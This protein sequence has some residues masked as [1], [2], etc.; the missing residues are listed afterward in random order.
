MVEVAGNGLAEPTQIVGIGL[1]VGVTT[2]L[3]VTVNVVVVAHWFGFGV[4]VYVLV[5]VL[6]KIGL[7]PPMMPLLEVAGSGLAEPAQIGAI[8]LKVG[9]T[10]EVTVTVIVA[11]VAH[12]PAVGVNV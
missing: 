1:K 8:V 7:Q 4:K 9:T 3:T 11:V 2:G 12:C 10:G 5:W 6:S